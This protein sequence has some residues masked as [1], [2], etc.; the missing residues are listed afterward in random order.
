MEI[1]CKEINFLIEQSLRLETSS[2]LLSKEFY[3]RHQR[4]SLIALEQLMMMM[5]MIT[6]QVNGQQLMMFFSSKSFPNEM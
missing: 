2:T 5:M 1:D 6:A 3:D 4:S